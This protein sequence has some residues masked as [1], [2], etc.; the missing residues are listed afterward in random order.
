MRCFQMDNLQGFA[1]L[2]GLP[3]PF[4]NKLCL[5]YTLSRA[6]YAYAYIHITDHALSYLRSAAWWAGNF[7]CFYA[8]YATGK[9]LNR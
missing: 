1:Q 3:N 5:A 8:L 2:A 9:V 6:V 7:T 4:I